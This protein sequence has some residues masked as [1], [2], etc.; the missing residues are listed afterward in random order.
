MQPFVNPCY[1]HV[2]SMCWFVCLLSCMISVLPPGTKKWCQ[3]RYR[4]YATLYK[5]NLWHTL[6]VT[7]WDFVRSNPSLKNA[8]HP[9]TY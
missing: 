5:L 7:E 2:S 4:G 8:M 3:L 1:G 9:K 6:P